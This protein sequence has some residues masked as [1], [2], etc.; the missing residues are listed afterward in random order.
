MA[1]GWSAL[2]G[3]GGLIG[4]LRSTRAQAPCGGTAAVGHRRQ[5]LGP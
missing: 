3:I 2:L 4:Q 5:Q 1:S